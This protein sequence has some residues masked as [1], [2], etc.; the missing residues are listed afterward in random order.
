MKKGLFLVLA[1]FMAIGMAAPVNAGEMGSKYDVT[2]YGYIK[3]DAVYQDSYAVM[4]N[5]LVQA[6]PDELAMAGA[7]TEAQDMDTFSMTARQSRFGFLITTPATDSGLV[8]R[9]RIEA[10]FYGSL[11]ARDPGKDPEENKGG[12]ML[13]RATVEIIADSWSILAGNE[14]M[15]MSPLFPH[16]NNY[17]Y[18]ADAGN[19]GYR[20]PQ[21]RLTGYMMDKAIILQVAATNKI[22]DV[23]GAFDIDT[24]RLAAVPTWE[25]GVTYKKDGLVLALTGHYGEEEI[26]TERNGVIDYHGTRIESQSVNVSFNLPLGDMFGV[27]GEY[28]TGSNLD[29]WYTGAQGSG[30]VVTEDWDREAVKS[31]GGWVELMAKPVDGVKCHVGYGVDDPDDDQLEDGILE[32]LYKDGGDPAVPGYDPY[33]SNRAP[34]LNT[35]TY[36]NVYYSVSPSTMIA[37]EW[38]Q[39]MT[40]YD[41][42]DVDGTVNRYT[43]SFWYIF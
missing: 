15:V 31:Q 20:T 3:L 13:R 14:W 28:F 41:N 17:P 11:P 12:L 6:L 10:D 35:M 7:E 9:G 24:G 8:T 1:I 26:R 43:L 36:G 40:D 38:M 33:S 4:D 27:S 37:M 2:F 32:Q 5:F 25:A 29:G 19:L 23:D 39:M 22:G 34:T 21:I 18:G 16:V 30:W 42:L